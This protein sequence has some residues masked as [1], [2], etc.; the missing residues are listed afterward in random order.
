VSDVRV[1][2]HA[3]VWYNAMLR[4]D[5]RPIVVRE[6]ANVQGGCVLRG[7][8]DPVTEIGAG[9]TD[10][11]GRGAHRAGVHPVVPAHEA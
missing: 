6:G 10:G 2:A 4:A 7:G 8:T 11:A 1:E 5:F 9:A 3:S